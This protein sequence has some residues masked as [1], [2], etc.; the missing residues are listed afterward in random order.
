MQTEML[1]QQ[2][3]T[4]FT[5]EE[6]E[7]CVPLVQRF[8]GLVYLARRDGL[9]PLEEVANKEKNSFFK[10]GFQ[11]ILDGADPMKVERI[12]YTLI[13]SGNYSGLPLL[14]RL[15]MTVGILGIQLGENPHLLA[16]QMLAMLGE[17]YL[18]RQNE[19]EELA[20]NQTINQS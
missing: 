18:S 5:N 15:I 9:L 17:E 10:T 20:R 4:Q 19:I 7:N 14:E 12:L 16:T 1:M 11:L 2:L 13:I 8:I 3:N 6:K